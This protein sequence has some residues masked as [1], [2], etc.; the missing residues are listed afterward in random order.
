MEEFFI[1]RTDAKRALLAGRLKD[2]GASDRLNE[3]AGSLSKEGFL[4]EAAFESG[5]PIQLRLCHCP[6]RD[7]VAVTHLPCR[8]EMKLVEVLLG[9]PLVRTQF[10]PDGDTSCT[11]AIA[12]APRRKREPASAAGRTRP[13]TT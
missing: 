12:A 5:E 7:L 11:Y 4:A 13:V 9:R 2:L 1:A 10:M 6:L 8:A 3:I